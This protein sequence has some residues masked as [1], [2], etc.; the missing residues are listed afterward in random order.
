M[1]ICVCMCC[2]SICWKVPNLTKVLSQ[3]MIKRGLFDHI[4]TLAVRILLLSVLQFLNTIGE[5]TYISFGQKDHGYI[6]SILGGNGFLWKS[7]FNVGEQMIVRCGQSRITRSVI[8]NS[9]ATIMHCGFNV[10]TSVFLDDYSWGCLIFVAARC[11]CSWRI[12][13]TFRESHVAY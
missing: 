9:K 7:W 13:N 1:R 12:V 10:L 2:T 3:N 5:A 4:V 8:D 11:Y 6:T